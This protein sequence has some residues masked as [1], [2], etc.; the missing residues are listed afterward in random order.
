MT[1]HNVAMNRRLENLERCAELAPDGMY[2]HARGVVAAIHEIS[3]VAL[4]TLRDSGLK[5]GNDDRLRNLEVALYDYV[6]QSNPELTELVAAEGFGE[7]TDGP[8]GARV[9]EQAR[10][11]RD[12]LETIRG[13]Q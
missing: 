10:R 6:L 8:A 11:D 12:A 5:A 1:I 4:Y 3:T 9:V 2:V 13:R 7:H